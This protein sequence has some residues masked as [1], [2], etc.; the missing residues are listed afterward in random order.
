MRT[1]LAVAFVAAMVACTGLLV[2]PGN[3]FPCDYSKP[4]GERDAVCSKGDV[5]GVDDRCR[6][7]RYEGPQFEGLPTFPTFADPSVLHPMLLKGPIDAIA[8]VEG[9][10]PT[11]FVVQSGD[12]SYAFLSQRGSTVELRRNLTELRDPIVVNRLD[13]GLRVIG[14]EADGQVYFET[15]PTM[16]VR[17]PAN[18]VAGLR[19]SRL[20]TIDGPGIVVVATNPERAGR[21]IPTAPDLVPDFNSITADGP[22]FDV[23]SAAGT[24]GLRALVFAG[25]D[26]F[27]IQA[28]GGTLLVVSAQFPAASAVFADERNTLYA[29]LSAPD[30]GRPNLATYGVTRTSDTIRLDP[31]WNDCNPCPLGAVPLAVTPGLDPGPFVDLLCP[32]DGLRRIRGALGSGPS[33]VCVAD[34]TTPLFDPNA[35]ILRRPGDS[36]PYAVFDTAASVGFLAGGKAGRVWAGKTIGEATPIFLDRVPTDVGTLDFLSASGLVA[37]TPVGAFFRPNDLDAATKSNGFRVVA[38]DISGKVGAL[39]HDGQGWGLSTSGSLAKIDLAGVRFGPQLVDGLG[40]RPQR[41]LFGEGLTGSDGG[42]LS[43]VI[44][45]DDSLYFLATPTDLAGSPGLR[46]EATPVLTPEASTRIRSFAV[47]RTPVGTNGVDRVRGYLVTSRNVYEFELGGSPLQWSS[48]LL[49]LSGVEPVEVWFDNPR[50]G[51]GR[52]GYRDGTIFS[53]PGGFQ[54]TEPLPENDAGL[55]A[56]VIDYENLGGW[57]VALTSAGL[58]LARY[59]V[60]PNGRLDSRFPD[61]G[62]G[63]LMTW[64]EITLPNGAR[65]WIA[66]NRGEARPGRLFVSAEPQQAADGGGYRRRFH[67]VLFMPDAVIEL[68]QHERSNVSALMP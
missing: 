56:T 43:M 65:P 32:V 33:A 11:D 29:V 53:L 50:G 67:L 36:K 54:L 31:I 23:A 26:G 13:S 57:P 37:V 27:R 24:L 51:L 42:L 38:P 5:C 25:R 49:A 18:L 7:F 48:S 40:A 61:G 34:E 17:D 35:L 3:D 14:R 45:A 15:S 58:F 63:K 52:A 30:A 10:G 1:F 21:I 41:V 62:L 44:A 55:P 20:R 66:G 59:D 46:G 28:D 68:G 39:V 12:A 60:L 2:E 8:H 16:R 6:R 19:A 22:P 9:G 64:R 4:P 47:E